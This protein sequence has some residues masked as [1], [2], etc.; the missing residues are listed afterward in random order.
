VLLFGVAACGPLPPS[1]L[2]VTDGARDGA[3]ERLPDAPLS[4]RGVVATVWTGAELLLIGG[5]TVDPDGEYDC[6]LLSVCEAPETVV[7]ADGA[8]LD[9]ATGTW[10]RL[11]DRPGGGVTGTRH[12]WTGTEA[13]SFGA[14]YDVGADRWRELA[15][16]EE[17]LVYDQPS[18]T[19]D[20][21]V[22]TGWSYAHGG[23][24][25]V[26][27]F[28]AAALDPEGGAWR[29]SAW[30]RQPPGIEGVASVWTGA[31]LLAFVS[32]DDCPA[33][34]G[35]ICTVLVGWEPHADRWRLAGFLP[36]GLRRSPIWTGTELIISGSDPDAHARLYSVD[37][38]DRSVDPL[39][40]APPGV[41]PFDPVAGPAALAVVAD[42]GVAVFDLDTHVWRALPP[43]PASAPS[44]SR[45]VA[46]AG[47]A[48]VV[49]GGSRDPA[50][51]GSV[52]S[53]EGWI[54]AFDER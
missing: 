22:T 3:W 20:L 10:R 14:A 37:P 47:D 43:L 30:P 36:S 15:G 24:N 21:L 40:H 7:N 48:L 41:L 2:P 45:A 5:A 31:E 6:P 33:G 9:P 11:A 51:E 13:M 49:W 19:G 34:T 8:A 53:A 42:A 46:W 16:L 12:L 50:L 4:P 25:G 29:V 52:N 27:Q 35:P 28:V 17:V 1:G 39:P 44:T 23:R 26:G 54:L 38:A 18:W 32:T